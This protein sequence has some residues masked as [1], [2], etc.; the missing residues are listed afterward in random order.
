[1]T[2]ATA[3]PTTPHHEALAFLCGRINYERSGQIPY[4]SRELKLDRMREL[5]SLIG[6]PHTRYPIVHIAGTK[7]KGSTAHM[8]AS[9]LTAAGLRTGL[10]TSPHLERVEER[11]AIDGEVCSEPEFATLVADLRPAIDQLDGKAAAGER[12]DQGPTF[13]EITTAMAMRHFANRRVDAAVLEVG[14]GGRLDSTNVCQPA[15]TVITSISFDHTEQL[16]D[17][18]A[19][20]ATEKAGI[21]K[22][23]VPVIS[24]VIKEEPRAVIE[25]IARERG[26]RLY[27]RDA[28]FFC[29]D[30]EPASPA[31]AT[32]ADQSHFPRQLEYGEKATLTD[33]NGL[34]TNLQLP[35]FGQHQVA[36]AGLAISTMMRLREIGWQIPD[37][38]I[39]DGLRRVRCPARIECVRSRPHVLLDTAHNVVSAQALAHSLGES[40]AQVR[41]KLLIFAVSQDKD[42][43]G[44]L[45]S[46]LPQFDRVIFTQFLQNPRARTP[47]ELADLAHRVAAELPP[48][49]REIEVADRPE[50][51]WQRAVSVTQPD[52]L[53]CITG[54]FFLAAELRPLVAAPG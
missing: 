34:L 5:L 27:L 50:T 49:P 46:L 14:L 43:A 38:A 48:G 44:M 11:L 13:F 39:R 28:D 10:Y 42:A 41:H 22:P 45:T 7:G 2:A 29:R 36:N 18:L 19:A 53:I 16:G 37:A 30:V 23:G 21:I 32:M 15:V 35:L 51:A 12:Y 54:S 9:I 17:T 33:R 6:D 52:D 47:Q 4:R 40:F 24:G 25:Q 26:S 3:S 31:A 8:I 1:M 20:I